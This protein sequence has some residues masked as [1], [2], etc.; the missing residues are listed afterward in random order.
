[1]S[2]YYKETLNILKEKM[3]VISKFLV[4]FYSFHH[5]MTSEFLKQLHIRKSCILKESFY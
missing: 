5:K 2:M 3:L 1:M 4:N